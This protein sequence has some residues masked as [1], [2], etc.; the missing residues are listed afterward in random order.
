ME[1]F[2]PTTLALQVRCSGQL[3]YTGVKQ[4]L[5][6]S[7]IPSVCG[8]PPRMGS[9]VSRLTHEPSRYVLLECTALIPLL[10]VGHIWLPCQDT[11]NLTREYISKKQSYPSALITALL[12][13]WLDFL[14]P[15]IIAD[16]T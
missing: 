2:E 5:L 7:R 3:S 8:G 12:P 1:G 6:V 10:L 15:S 13:G 9:Y 14:I 4:T 16:E 11:H